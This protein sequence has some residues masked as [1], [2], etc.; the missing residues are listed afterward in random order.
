[1]AS[2]VVSASQSELS[3]CLRH[4][5]QLGGVDHPDQAVEYPTV[6]EGSIANVRVLPDRLGDVSTP[7]SVKQGMTMAVEEE[8]WDADAHAKTVARYGNSGAITCDAIVGAAG[9]Q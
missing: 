4:R 9:P 1:M 7:P 5:G 6:S 8:L 2:R 3:Q